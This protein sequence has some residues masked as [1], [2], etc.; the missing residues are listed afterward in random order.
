MSVNRLRLVWRLA[1]VGWHLLYGLAQCTALFPLL[2][3]RRR[4]A[5]VQRWSRQLTDL[6]GISIEVRLRGR[7]AS[8]GAV[9]ANH[10][11]WIDV[12]VMNA[13]APCRFIAKSDVRRWPAIGWLSARAGTLYIRRDRRS[14]LIDANA[15]IAYHL[16]Q[17]E[18][19][20]FFPEGTSGP[21]GGVLPFHANL[22]E[23]VV[24]ARAPVLPMAIVYFDS[25]GRPSAAAEYIGDTSLWESMIRLLTNGPFVATV[26]LLPPID[27]DGTGRRALAS[28]TH[29][30]V[31]EGLAQALGGTASAVH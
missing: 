15:T 23:A 29:T 6:F 3:L 16:T 25:D 28:A 22:F 31:S 7:T 17:G 19:V 18:R 27:P 5:L 30:A 12:F 9:V 13:V 20:A 10:V 1:R 26:I 11:S 14:A 4:N 21:Q 24:Q 8:A 2:S